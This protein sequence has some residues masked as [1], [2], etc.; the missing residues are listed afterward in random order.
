MSIDIETLP[1]RRARPQEAKSLYSGNP[2]DPLLAAILAVVFGRLFGLILADAEQRRLG[3]GML[4]Q[5]A[6]FVCAVHHAAFRLFLLALD[7]AFDL[8]T[9]LL[10]PRLLFLPLGKCGPA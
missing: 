7:P 4:S 3:L 5:L 10:L 8:L 6:H 2:A 1:R 9:L